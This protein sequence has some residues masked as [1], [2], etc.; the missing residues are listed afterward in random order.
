MNSN[1]LDS[2][3][4]KSVS[5]IDYLAIRNME[6]LYAAKVRIAHLVEL[7]EQKLKADKQA[8]RDALNPLTY[9]NRLIAKI[10][11][12]DYLF[13]YAVK[14]Y[15][16]VK[17]LFNKHTPDSSSDAP[18]SPVEETATVEDAPSAEVN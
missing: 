4:G 7:K 15:D 16:F 9:I 10:Y 5:G 2:K 1:I 8:V 11:S 17:D 18:H 6:Q 13:K 14:G 12:M 3:D